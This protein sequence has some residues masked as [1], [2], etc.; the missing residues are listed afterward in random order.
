M[1]YFLVLL[2]SAFAVSIGYW[3]WYALYYVLET[4]LY[5]VHSAFALR[6]TGRLIR[7]L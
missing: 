1:K 4:N 7:R 5:F 6:L 2:L 3:V